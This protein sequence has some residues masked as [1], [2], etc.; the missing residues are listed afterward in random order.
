M[1]LCVVQVSFQ[2]NELMYAT[3]R[4]C[5]DFHPQS[6]LSIDRPLYLSDPTKRHPLESTEQEE[7]AKQE[8]RDARIREIREKGRQKKSAAVMHTK[9]ND[10]S[11]E[12]PEVQLDSLLVDLSAGGI[13]D[14]ARQPHPIFD[15]EDRVHDL[16]HVTYSYPPPP[17]D[18]EKDRDIFDGPPTPVDPEADEFQL[19]AW[20]PPPKPSASA[21]DMETENEANAKGRAAKSGGKV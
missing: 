21:S 6:F 3:L 14:P 18:D 12:K 8:A 10:A 5:I 17:G 15:D 19:V 20:E 16:E 9:N 13:P 2:V 4:G 1:R 7:K 11:K